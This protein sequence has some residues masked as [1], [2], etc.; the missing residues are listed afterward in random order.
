MHGESAIARSDGTRVC[1]YTA[2]C[3]DSRHRV[4]RRPPVVRIQ[5]AVKIGRDTRTG[6]NVVVLGLLMP[7]SEPERSLSPG[8]LRTDSSTRRF[9][10]TRCAHRLWLDSRTGHTLAMQHISANE[11]LGHASHTSGAIAF[12]E[13]LSCGLPRR[14]WWVRASGAHASCNN[15]RA[16]AIKSGPASDVSIECQGVR[17]ALR[18]ARSAWK[19]SRAM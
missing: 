1:C 5:Y 12:A 13:L 19:I 7:H 2:S 17:R 6:L 3:L 14:V 10:R 9:V 8:T 11:S 18:S 16:S 4:S 15:C